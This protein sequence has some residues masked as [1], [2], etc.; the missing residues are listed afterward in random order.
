MHGKNENI[1]KGG[2]EGG[3]GEL[4]GGGGEQTDDAVMMPTIKVHV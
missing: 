4:E 3:R 1:R 2:G